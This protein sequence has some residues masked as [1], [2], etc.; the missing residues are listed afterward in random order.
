M[1]NLKSLTK[2]DIENKRCLVRVD[3]NS[4]FLDG[5]IKNN[6][7]IE[8]TLLL[9]NYL[10]E[11][12]AK[13]ILM[14][15][16]EDNNGSVPHLDEFYN[17]LK[18]NFFEKNIQENIHFAREIF[19]DKIKNDTLNLIPGN[20]MLL[21]NLRLDAREEK[22]DEEFGRELSFLG[23]IYINEAFS[24]SHRKHTSIVEVPKFIPSFPGFNFI[25]EIK[26]LSS[27]FNPENPFFV[28]IGGKKT[29]TKE[30][31]ISKFL[32][33]AEGIILGGVM[34]VEFYRAK[35][36]NTGKTPFDEK[37]VHMIK[38]KFLDNNGNIF[39][40]IIIPDN[41]IILRDN[42]K[43]EANINEIL[44]DDFIYDIAPSFFESLKKEIIS[45]KMILWNGPMGF[46][47]QGFAE[48]T[49][50][51]NSLFKNSNAKIIAGGGETVDF[52]K[53]FNFEDN[54]SFISTGG[55]AMLQFLADETLP[56]IHALTI[57]K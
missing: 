13:I 37:S 42:Q 24:A 54:F 33:K 21:D 7:R 38:E 10:M 51:L 4:C 40:K 9:L 53:S 26:N 34:A 50:K 17:E 12:K 29:S 8:K 25:S 30:Q 55:G 56:G 16:I 11:N 43:I 18:T 20:I 45:A 1:F 41:F 31:V 15:H 2:Q 14:T 5:K 22:G 46:V 3:F 49:L 32:D 48:G 28:F 47:E 6:F 44:D 57:S 36:M 23:D 19:N 35:N 52:I 27:L 39:K